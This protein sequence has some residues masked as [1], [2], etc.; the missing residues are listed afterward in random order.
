MFIIKIYDMPAS[1]EEEELSHS[2]VTEPSFNAC[3]TEGLDP[4]SVQYNWNPH[5]LLI[6][7]FNII[8][9]ISLVLQTNPLQAI[10]LLKS[11]IHFS[12]HTSPT[13][14]YKET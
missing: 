4:E 2:L 7:Q 8:S 10:S 13:H 5:N 1:F 14:Q 12:S 6:I 9:C 3:T 11:R